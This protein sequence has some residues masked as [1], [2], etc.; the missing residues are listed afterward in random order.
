MIRQGNVVTEFII[1]SQIIFLF[2][3]E[4]VSSDIRHEISGMKVAKE[5]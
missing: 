2:V 1:L 5:W 3:A 4:Y